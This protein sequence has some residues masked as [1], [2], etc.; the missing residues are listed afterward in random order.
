M[1]TLRC[2]KKLLA[3]LGST[4]AINEVQPTTRLGDWHANLLFRPSG[5]VVLFAN[6]RTLLPVLVP[7]APASS[8]LNR[9][10]AAAAYL[11]LRLGVP[12]AVVEAERSEMAEVRIRK[13]ASRQVL[14]SSRRCAW[15]P[16]GSATRRSSL[17]T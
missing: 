11:L 1:F 8:L 17:S 4:P 10:P 16:G 5:Q 7:A 2:T 13:T 12:A 9:F 15:A 6:E 14:G 3:R